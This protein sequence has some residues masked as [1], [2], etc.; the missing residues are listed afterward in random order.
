MST[1]CPPEPDMSHG[2]VW[3]IYDSYDIY[4]GEPGSPDV[5]Q[6]TDTPGYDAE[7]TID[8]NTG[9]MYFTSI[10]GGD[11]D[12]WRMNLNTNET[13]QLTDELGYDGGPFISYD[14]KT[15]VYRRSIIDTDEARE[16]Y[17]SLLAQDLI[18]PTELELMVMDADGSNKRQLTD[19]GA[20]NFAPFLHPDNDTIIFCSNLSDP[21]A[22]A[23]NLYTYKLSTGAIEQVTY[24]EG[25]DGFPMFSPDGKYLVWCSNRNNSQPHETNV[26]LAEWVP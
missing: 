24:F 23:F 20:A 9:W 8:W 13:Q 7:A 22:F 15:V 5:R 16:D 12:I 17:T 26:F 11:L 3:P 2:Y 4:L 18:R 19:N 1:G 14:G 6:L 10:R 25:F 21:G